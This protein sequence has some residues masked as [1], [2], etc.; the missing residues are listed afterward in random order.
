MEKERGEKE[1]DKKKKDDYISIFIPLSNEISNF[2]EE[3]NE[4]KLAV[5]SIVKTRSRSS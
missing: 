3:E 5:R 2:Q 1:G 4:K